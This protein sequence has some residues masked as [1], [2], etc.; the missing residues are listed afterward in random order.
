MKHP[1]ETTQ[2]KSFA[3]DQPQQV[4][5]LSLLLG[6]CALARPPPCAPSTSRWKRT[7]STTLG[8]SLD[9]NHLPNATGTKSWY[10]TLY[11]TH[12]S[13]WFSM[14]HHDS[15]TNL[16][17]DHYQSICLYYYF[18]SSSQESLQVLQAGNPHLWLKVL[19][20]EKT[21]RFRRF[22][23]GINKTTSW[24]STPI[25]NTWGMT[26]AIERS[27]LRTTGEVGRLRPVRKDPIEGELRR[28]LN[29]DANGTCKV[30]FW[31]KNLGISS[32]IIW[33]G[34]GSVMASAK[35][36]CWMSKGFDIFT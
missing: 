6:C 32:H 10:N 25:W 26:S 29:C 21:A 2:S 34:F 9:F 12:D 17:L 31:P 8:L 5:G 30:L 13:S 11:N 27:V 33:C 14:I 24:S 28:W 19:S 35:Q 7:P 18:K 1:L 16:K 4:I 36:H 23:P 22:T 15:F 20:T 3:V